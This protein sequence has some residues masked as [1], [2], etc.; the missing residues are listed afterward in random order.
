MSSFDKEEKHEEKLDEEE[1]SDQ[2]THIPSHFESTNDEAF[3]EVTQ[4][5][6]VEEE[7]LDKEKTYV[8]EEVNEM[9]NDMNINL[10]GR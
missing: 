3:N 5:D 2:R 4:G 8:E 10:E 1:G 9:Y 7:K 6:N